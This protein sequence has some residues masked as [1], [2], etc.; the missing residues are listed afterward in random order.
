MVSLGELV[1]NLEQTD[2]YLSAQSSFCHCLW[3]NQCL[4]LFAKYFVKH[5]GIN[6][7]IVMMHGMAQMPRSPHALF[8][9]HLK[10]QTFPTL[11]DEVPRPQTVIIL[12]L[13]A[14]CKHV[15]IRCRCNQMDA[16]QNICA[17]ADLPL[18]HFPIQNVYLLSRRHS[19]WWCFEIGNFI[20]TASRIFVGANICFTFIEGS[21]LTPSRSSAGSTWNLSKTALLPDR[22]GRPQS[23]GALL[24]IAPW[25]RFSI[26]V[27]LFWVALSPRMLGCTTKIVYKCECNG[28]ARPLRQ[29]HS[30]SR[31]WRWPHHHHPTDFFYCLPDINIGQIRSSSSYI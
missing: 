19:S 15:C 28:G 21:I 31:R 30:C 8:S 4:S 1:W 18:S 11:R 10:L 25:K 24:E 14:L 17:L 29:N 6:N 23:L 9:I 5:V 20:Y 3:S 26:L 7:W 13:V 27:S 22:G 12:N 16:S 2:H